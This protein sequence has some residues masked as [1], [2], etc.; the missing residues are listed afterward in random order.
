MIIYKQLYFTWFLKKQIEKEFGNNSSFMSG[1]YFHVVFIH[2][3]TPIHPF[4]KKTKVSLFYPPSTIIK[5]QTFSFLTV[6]FI[7]C[8]FGKI[9]CHSPLSCYLCS[10]QC[11]THHRKGTYNKKNVHH[12]SLTL[13]LL[14]SLHPQPCYTLPS[15]YQYVGSYGN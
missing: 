13:P 5:W 10:F 14:L 4:I 9:N 1:I 8:I 15:P 11:D 12:V 3:F 6:Y 2:F 7:P